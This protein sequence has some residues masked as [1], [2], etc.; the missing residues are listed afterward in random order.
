MESI[1][2]ED[3]ATL[4]TLPRQ[5]LDSKSKCNTLLLQLPPSWTVADL[6]DTKFVG[7]DSQQVALVSDTKEISFSCHHV[8]TSN[9]WIMI[10]PADDTSSNS[11]KR[12]KTAQGK[13]LIPRK[14]R[15]LKPGGS[16]AS[17]LE[18][19][20]HSFDV[21][22]ALSS[23]LSAH[24]LD[25]YQNVEGVSGRTVESLANELQ[26]SRAQ[27]QRGLQTLE[28]FPIPRTSSFCRL[29][30][31]ATLEAYHAIVSS[32]AEVE[33]LQAYVSEMVPFDRAVDEALMRMDQFTY[34]REILQHCLQAL[35][36]EL[37]HDDTLVRLSILKVSQTILL[38]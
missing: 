17:F 10:P 1:K 9:V 37:N 8:E 2:K 31:E 7:S 14:A 29:G 38:T 20:E 33:E 36:T 25:P 21:L 5:D 24:V 12:T 30:E 15:L 18:L 23:K 19:R 35:S 13:S 32:L 28:A 6:R 26:V 4:L 11:A 34:G 3:I 27:I 22:A 16:G